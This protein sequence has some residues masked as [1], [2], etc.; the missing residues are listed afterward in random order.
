[1]ALV[2]TRPTK[3]PK[4]GIWEVRKG[5]PKALRA[6]IGVRELKRSLGT[7]DDAEARRRG[8]AVIAEF[9]A[10]IA[11]AWAQHRGAAASLSPQEVAAIVGEWYRV[12]GAKIDAAPG[13]PDVRD[14]EQDIVVNDRVDPI[15]G[16]VTATDDDQAT[17]DAVLALRGIAADETTRRL[18]AT[19]IAGARID[20]AV[21]AVRRAGGRWAPDPAEAEFPALVSREPTA[22]AE[23]LRSAALL[24]AWATETRPAPST[25][26]KYRATFRQIERVL[27]FDDVRRITV[28]DVVRFKEARL[29][30]G[31]DVGTV[32]DD[33]LS[34]G[35]VF[36]WAVR[37]GKVSDNP[38]A[39][40]APKVNRRGPA[41]RAP[42][43]DE[44]AARI[45]TAARQES[46]ALRWLPWLLCFTGARIGE[47]AEL[48]RCAVQRERDVPFL[49]IRPTETRA[50]KNATM[51]R[52]VPLHPA[53]ISEGF[54][55]YV[56]GLPANPDGPLFPDLA[57]DPRGSRVAPA[58]G[59]IGR[60]MRRSVGITDKRK[61]P[62]HSWRHRMED[63]LRKV[64]AP[65]EV[66]DAITGR[67]NPRNAGAGYGLGF[68][69]M[70]DE[71]LK[72]LRRIPSP[73]EQRAA[74]GPE[75]A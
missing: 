6:I 50:G 9:E 55:D 46:G 8:P 19:A 66:Q 13:D 26:K 29:A 39:Q 57:P 33:V 64:R 62:A 41:P 61:A 56:A 17:A 75:D 11:A 72:D 20:L 37:N 14:V 65:A 7:K 27:G 52:M 42:Y 69:G 36:R 34:A 40:M 70:P 38:C 54:L 25:L 49:D 35:A 53:L 15:E 22:K 12:E 32:A 67:Y 5:V 48:R 47:L 18:T 45:L 73:L 10:R 44:E 74:Q 16:D 59:R 30:E 24:A 31:K 4:S 28:A 21:R 71:V 23:P 2:M 63:E 1:M 68:R 51:Q 3:D 58:Q 60:W 43:D